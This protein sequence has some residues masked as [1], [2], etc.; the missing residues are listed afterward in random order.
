MKNELKTYC[1]SAIFKLAKRDIFI[2]S[3]IISIWNRFLLGD[4]TVN[5]IRIWILVVLEKWIAKNI[6]T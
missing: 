5:W 6:E 2:E 3:E 1:E 4:K